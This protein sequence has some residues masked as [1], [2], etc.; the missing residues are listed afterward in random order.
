LTPLIAQALAALR[1]QYG[2]A[3][4]EDEG[5]DGPGLV[6]DLLR[7]MQ[8]TRPDV[9][10][11]A[12]LAA[13]CP[14][15][16]VNA[17]ALGAIAG[18]GT[19]TEAASCL[20]D[21]SFVTRSYADGQQMLWMHRLFAAAIR[22]QTWNDSPAVAA[23]TISRLL[24]DTEQGRRIFITASDSSMLSLMERGEN[25]GEGG[26][27]HRAA[28]IASDPVRAGLLW[29]HLGHIREQRGPVSASEGHFGKALRLL[30]HDA[31][32]FE[33]AESLI[34]QARVTFQDGQST[35]EQLAGAQALVG[36]AFD[37]L[38]PLSDF[39]ARQMWEQGNALS[40]LIARKMAGRERSPAKRESEL[41]EVR[42]HLWRSYEAR[43]HLIRDRNSETVE[44]GTPPAPS[45]GLGA[46]RAYFNLAGTYLALAKARRDLAVDE[47]A[48][49]RALTP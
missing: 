27:V 19:C 3:P 2:A 25:P 31:Y 9:V 11:L 48:S 36:Q 35:N 46:E 20:A 34:G 10:E 43:L 41:A 47:E 49:P 23:G 17:A 5:T 32:P 7:R 12:R 6:W 24:T 38:A 21:L 30:D 45:D 33:T 29:Y 8:S 13:W 26:E 39:E 15:E 14:P 18:Y 1:K 22:R 40:W 44:P 42:D 4:P 16:P 28:E 37:Q